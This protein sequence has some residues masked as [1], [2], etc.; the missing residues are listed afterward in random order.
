MGTS[1]PSAVF[2]RARVRV[3]LSHS[4][5]VHERRSDLR[6]IAAV[7][8]ASVLFGTTGTAQELGPDGSTP[9]GVGAMR[10]IVG[11]ITLWCI[12]GR[13][14]N[15]DV[16]KRQPHLL[17]LGGVCVAVYQPGFFLGI[18]R[19]G[20]ALG[21]FVALGSGP[22]FAGLLELF[23]LQ[24]RPPTRWI[25]ATA[26]ML[27]GGLLLV[28]GRGGGATF[29]VV[30][31]FG[32]LAAGFGYALFA[33]VNKQMIERGVHSTTAMAWEFTIGSPILAALMIGQ[34]V[35]W[36]ATGGGAAMALYLGVVVTGLA[37]LLYGWGLRVIS[38]S[39]AVTLTLAEP[40][41]AAVVAVLI[42]DERLEWFGW[43]G[44]V[45]VVIGLLIAARTS[46]TLES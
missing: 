33:I 9:L 27:L 3:D 42:L 1:G 5:I 30:G 7:L 24:R 11:A 14:P 40:V 32:S 13:F 20:V 17:V 28:I 19:S 44:A 23:W 4:R 45:G 31:T 18:E 2:H 36:L 8:A 22:V 26:V 12:V 46:N 25:I 34:P 16:L 43:L 29:S 6:A 35:G 10:L 38:T 39:T 37:Y 21:T 41:T 15:L